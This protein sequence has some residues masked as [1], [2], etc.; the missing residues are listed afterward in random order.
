MA[1]IICPKCENSFNGDDRNNM[2]T[3]A[4]AAAVLAGVGTQIG[5]SIGLATGGAGMPATI[6]LGIGGGIIGYLSASK[7]RKCPICT[8][9]FKV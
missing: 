6:P 2:T 9:I 5:G 3:R 7:F 4:A 1:Q 8:K